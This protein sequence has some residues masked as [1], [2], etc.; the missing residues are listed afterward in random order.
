MFLSGEKVQEQIMDL[1]DEDIQ[2]Q[3][4]GVDLTVGAIF[5]Y[6]EVGQI[7]FDNSERRL[8]ELSQINPDNEW[9]V[10]QPGPYLVR[11]NETVSI[12]LGCVGILFPRSTLMREGCIIYSALW[13]AGYNGRGVGLLVV[14]NPF[15]IRIKR[16][17]RIGQ[18][19][20]VKAEKGEDTYAGV[21]KNEGTE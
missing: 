15:G 10:L 7:D 5:K 16:N 18:I 8:P 4:N 21:Y 17:A 20:L 2:K 13:D 14:Y 6:L 11:Y 19:T 9:Y 1:I 3:P 12:P